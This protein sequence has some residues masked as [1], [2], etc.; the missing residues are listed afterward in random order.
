MLVKLP[1]NKVLAVAPGFELVTG[2]RTLK[3]ADLLNADGIAR[4]DPILFN[5][6]TVGLA[7]VSLPSVLKS[8][9][10]LSSLAV[11]PANDQQ[12]K[13]S[14]QLIKSAAALTMLRG[15]QG[16]ITVGNTVADRVGGTIETTVGNT[17]GTTVG[18]TVGNTIQNVSNIAD[19][20]LQTA[21]GLLTGPAIAGSASSIEQVVVG[22]LIP[23]PAVAQANGLLVTLGAASAQTNSAAAQANRA[24][25]QFI[26]VASAPTTT[27][28]TDAT[29]VLAYR[30]GTGTDQLPTRKSGKSADSGS[31][32][33]SASR[34]HS[35]SPFL[36]KTS[37]DKAGQ[38]WGD[39]HD[40][41]EAA[42]T[43]RRLASLSNAPLANTSL[44]AP[45][46]SV[47]Q[48][49][50]ANQAQALKE[51]IKSHPDIALAVLAL[52]VMLMV[53][54]I[55][56][57]HTAR[58]RA[59]QA[60]AASALLRAQAHELTMAR[61]QALQASRLKN[62]F[63]ANISH[64]IRT[65]MTAVLGTIN[66]LFDTKLDADQAEIAHVLKNSARSLLNVI[67]DIL[68]FS[69][70]EAGKLS[71]ENVEFSPE[72]VV[73]EVAELLSGSAKEK[74]LGLNT[75]IAADVP[76]RLRGDPIRLKQILM[77]LEGNAVK[78]TNEG[79]VLLS[80]SKAAEQS[81]DGAKTNL[82]FSVKDS[83]I[84]I[85]P[86][87]SD[88][89]FQAFVQADGTTTRRFGGTGLG[90]SISRSL[91]ELMGGSIN[92]AST[93][94]EGAE[95][96]LTVPFDPIEATTPS[97]SS[98]SK[99]TASAPLLHSGRRVL[100]AEDNQV[101]QRIV[102]RQLEKLA[103]PVDVV[104]NGHAALEAIVSGAY[105]LVL[106]DWQMPEMDGLQATNA[107]RNLDS[108]KSHIPIIAMTANA[109]E[110][111]KLACLAAGMDDY[112]SKPFTM[113]QLKDVL[114][115]WM[116]PPDDA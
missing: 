105:A 36:R 99:I 78:F 58:I 11:S 91:A 19:N 20:V 65:P 57:A 1:S 25:G 73:R 92:F 71:L 66:L 56:L 50:L 76:A 48:S 37:D 84:G 104:N 87:S 110:S 30:F 70:I 86:E 55:Y 33:Q 4:R 81:V 96:W 35:N 54:T 94:G 18:T 109:M 103:Y 88:K 14:R 93:L 13:L 12:R 68:D 39:V 111:D 44:R 8:T 62:E 108:E 61:D 102:T 9:A 112:I 24:S 17:V 52:V 22:R 72:T 10:A 49:A 79:A 97:P 21:P 42:L 106:M 16:F 7:E 98:D 5:G 29:R 23:N 6:G 32:P 27:T 77:N 43:K 83:G 74:H 115:R 64:E 2:N 47:P 38:H 51:S 60:E 75:F 45:T 31:L 26:P 15:D 63:V 28:S 34:A 114:E 113:E 90:L 69:K 46:A 67:N 41:P 85:A 3:P 101:L 59:R 82:R 107:V 116:P 100:V 80:L 89:L 40:V 53:L 95:F